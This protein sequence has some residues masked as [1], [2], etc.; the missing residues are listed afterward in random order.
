M[1]VK[2]NVVFGK[3]GK[4]MSFQQ[5][6]WGMVGGD[7]EAPAMLS[8]LA[9][10]NPNINFYLIGRNDWPSLS[11]D[12]Q[13]RHNVNNN[14]IDIWQTYSSKRD[15]EVTKWPLK[16]LKDIKIGFGIIISGPT[17]FSTI[18]D[19]MP[20]L[21]GTRIA[22][23][24]MMSERYVGPIT[25]FLNESKIKYIEIGEDPRY[26]PVVARDL[27]NRPRYICGTRDLAQHRSIDVVD[28]YHGKLIE[29]NHPVKD[30]RVS[31]MFMA[32]EPAENRLSTHGNR[33]NL[34]S[35]YSNGLRNQGGAQKFPAIKEYVLD[36][37]P[38]ATV[39]GEWPEETPGIKAYQARF[40][41]VPML[42]L[43]DQ[44]YDTKYAFMI[45]IQTGWP[46]SKFYKH[47]IFG[48]IPFF[49]PTGHTKYYDGLPEFLLLDS[50]IDFK[51][52]IEFLESNP[53]EYTKLWHKCQKML[54]DEYFTG[55]HFNEII[56]REIAA[57]IDC[58]QLKLHETK[59][60]VHNSTCLFKTT[61]IE[62]PTIQTEVN[63][64]SAFL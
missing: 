16:F 20:T 23:P 21:D 4:A 12:E 54:R 56:L 44:M 61:T 37:F 22:K 19:A 30:C 48:M 29:I 60:K 8:I 28:G 14:I 24:S 55:V 25:R 64:L 1:N 62:K 33:A 10:M 49:H 58:S 18:P 53:A 2:L 47:L 35:V 9:Q 15:G 38:T 57:H 31:H 45:P 40:K 52:K 39:Y 36:Q 27:F 13:A 50:A 63:D 5:G 34:L 3:I 26:F 17:G 51:K 59:A 11:P 32:S 7:H 6:K 43:V 41:P 46:T 42:E